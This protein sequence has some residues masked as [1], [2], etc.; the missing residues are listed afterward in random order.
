LILEDDLAMPVGSD[1]HH[2][3]LTSSCNLYLELSIRIL[4]IEN[5][6]LR[7][8]GGVPGPGETNHGLAG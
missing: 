8:S 3:H 4:R 5:N 2:N 7:K 1:F 6:R